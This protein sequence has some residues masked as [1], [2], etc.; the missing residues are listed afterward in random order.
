MG[1]GQYTKTYN[2]SELMKN[3]NPKIQTDLQLP[4]SINKKTIISTHITVKVW[5]IKTKRRFGL[6]TRINLLLW[7]S[8]HSVKNCGPIIKIIRDS[9]KGKSLVL[10]FKAEHVF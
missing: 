9:L 4:N 3:T 5:R 8:L 6:D 2:F 1:Q 7:S 10:L